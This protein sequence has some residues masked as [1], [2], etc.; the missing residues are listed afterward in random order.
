MANRG[1]KVDSQYQ[2]DPKAKAGAKNG[3]LN[4]YLRKVASKNIK[5]MF[6]GV[7]FNNGKA[8]IGKATNKIYTDKSNR[9]Q[10]NA[11]TLK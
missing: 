1:I 4:P 11:S 7:I 2:W 8:N 3:T 5:E 9:N 10:K 6:K